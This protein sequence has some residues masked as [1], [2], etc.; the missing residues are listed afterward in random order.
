M[1]AA[2][3]IFS[4]IGFTALFVA[5]S[6]DYW[7]QCEVGGTAGTGIGEARADGM[8]S[9]LSRRELLAS[10]AMAPTASKAIERS[11]SVPLRTADVLQVNDLDRRIW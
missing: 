3:Q 6:R 2:G 11:G 8:A 4:N 1:A 5:Q 9:E 10:L 7:I